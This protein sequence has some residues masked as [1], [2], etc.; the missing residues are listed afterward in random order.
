MRRKSMSQNFTPADDKGHTQRSEGL[1]T[2]LD[3]LASRM[4]STSFTS[5]SSNKTLLVLAMA[6]G[7]LL[8]MPTETYAWIFGISDAI[9]KALSHPQLSNLPAILNTDIVLP[10]L[11]GLGFAGAVVRYSKGGAYEQLV[12][13]GFTSLVS[14]GTGL[15]L[16][17]YVD[18]AATATA[19]RIALS[20]AVSYVG[21][22]LLPMFALTQFGAMALHRQNAWTRKLVTGTGALLVSGIVHYA[23][24]TIIPT[25]GL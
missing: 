1:S 20:T 15:T 5:C 22:V 10:L 8:S 16:E 11:A 2:S 13:V 17:S 24:T 19:S 12:F 3:A 25:H 9:G 4:A 6:V 7:A 18:H 14:L 21:N 23:Q